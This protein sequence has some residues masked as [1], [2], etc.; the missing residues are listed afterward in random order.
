MPISV[1]LELKAQKIGRELERI[2]NVDMQDVHKDLGQEMQNMIEERFENGVDPDGKDWEPLKRDY[3]R[4]G[5][6]LRKKEEKPLK[7]EQLF[8]SFGFTA[9]DDEVR[10]GT[11]LDHAKYHTDF[12]ANNQATRSKIPLREFMGVTK[13]ADFERLVEIIE[14]EFISKSALFD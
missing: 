9:T 6:R 14:K 7:F 11:P 10:V 3:K 1:Q 5:S 12:P 8:K 13:D 2:V 4:K